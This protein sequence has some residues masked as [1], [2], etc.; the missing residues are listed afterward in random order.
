MYIYIMMHDV[1]GCFY[2]RVWFVTDRLIHIIT[3]SL[4]P[5]KQL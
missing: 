1:Y 3:V 2:V 5:E 4:V